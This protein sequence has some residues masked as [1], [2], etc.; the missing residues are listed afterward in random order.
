MLLN[1][2]S[3]ERKLQFRRKKK[4]FHSRSNKVKYMKLTLAGYS[5]K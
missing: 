4:G 2:A 5:L 1:K 3:R